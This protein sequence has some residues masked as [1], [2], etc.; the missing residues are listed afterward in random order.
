MSNDKVQRRKQHRPQEL[1]EAG[2]EEFALNGFAATRMVDIAM[3]ANVSKGT[4][5]VYFKSKETLFEAAIR[6][7]ILPHIEQLDKIVSTYEGTTKDLIKLIVHLMYD[8]IIKTNASILIRVMIA[9]G[10]KFP[11]LIDFYY[12][13]VLKRGLSVLEKVVNRGIERGEIAGTA[14][15]LEPR[16]LIAPIVFAAVWTMLFNTQNPLNSEQFC[17]VHLDVLFNGILVKS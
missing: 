17:D 9:E 2:L 7:Q 5:Y 8:R 11:D 10:P 12:N 16:L 13:N 14:I 6:S 1:I 3:R 15:A 4:I